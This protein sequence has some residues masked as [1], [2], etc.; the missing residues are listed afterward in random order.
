MRASAKAGLGG[1]TAAARHAWLVI[2]ASSLALLFAA[3]PAHA[4]QTHLFEETFGSAEVPTLDGVVAGGVAVD[5]ATG[6]LLVIEAGKSVIRRFKPNGEPDP[7]TALGSNTIDGKKGVGGKEC[8][9][10]AAS[11]DQTP[12]NG[13]MFNQAVVPAQQLAVDNSGTLTDG[14]IYLTQGIPGSAHVV[15]VFAESGKYLGQVA[16]AGPTPFAEDEWTPCGVAVDESGNLYVSGGKKV[17]KFDPSASPPLSSDLTATYTDSDVICNLA[18]GAG[19][20]AGALFANRTWSL[21]KNNVIKL[22]TSNLASKGVVTPGVTSSVSVDPVTGHLFTLDFDAEAVG[23]RKLREYDVAGSSADLLSTTSPFSTINVAVTPFGERLYSGS[24]SGGLRVY[25]PTVTVPEPSTGPATEI[26]ESGVTLTGSVNPDGVPLEECRFAYGPSPG[27]LNE[28]TPC[29]ESNAEIGTSTKAVHARLEG[30]P[31]ETTY[32]YM[33]VAKN[34]NGSVDGSVQT[35]RTPGKPVIEGQWAVSVTADSAVIKAKVNP[36]NSPTTYRLEWGETP[37]YGQSASGAVGSDATGH[38]VSASLTGLAAGTAYHYRVV[39]SNNL[40]EVEGEDHYLTTYRLPSANTNC[41]NQ[42]F[43]TGAAAALPN[44][45]AYEMVSPV[46]KENGD[47]ISPPNITGFPVRRYQASTDGE[48]LSYTSIRAFADAESA[49]YTT[50]YIASRGEGGWLTHAITP[51]QGYNRIN[52][53]GVDNQYLASTPDL[54]SSWFLQDTDPPLTPDAPEGFANVYRRENATGGF[55]A[56][57]NVTPPHPSRPFQPQLRGVSEDGSHSVFNA[58]D[59]LTPNARTA[60]ISQVYETS[61]GG[62]LRLVSVM[63]DGTASKAD[64]SA[65]DR[66]DSQWGIRGINGYHAVSAD[67]MRVYWTTGAGVFL[68]EN[69]PREQSAIAAGKCTEPEK[70]CTYPVSGAEGSEFAFGAADGSRALFTKEGGGK[71]GLYRYDHADRSMHLIAPNVK[72]VAGASD[73]A[74]RVYFYSEEVLTGAEENSAG[75]AARAGQ[76][77]LYLYQEGEGLAYV[78]TVNKQDDFLWPDT[79]F[80]RESRVTP[81]GLH[82]AFTSTASLT[83]Y[84]NT[85]AHSGKADAEVFIYDAPAGGSPGLLRC[86]SCNPSG[87]RPVGRSLRNFN[88]ED[89]E[90]TAAK[91][92]G[93]DTGFY[94]SRYFSEDGQRLFFE[95]YDSL[96]LRDTNGRR[97]VYEW[98]ALGSGDCSEG[99]PSFSELNG[100]CVFLISSGESPEDSQFVDASP[101]GRDVFFTTSASLVSWQDTGLVD[102]YDARAGGGFAPPPSPAPACEGEACQGTPEAP[103]DPT[104]ASLSFEGAGNVVEAASSVK[105]KPSCAKG[106]VRRKGRCVVKKQRHRAKR[107]HRRAANDKGRAAR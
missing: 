51:P 30:L 78:A 11:C 55:E 72:R 48:K 102:V 32:R 69:A 84:D 74:L 65:G 70:A 60:N 43:R 7:F 17:Y 71:V 62:P 27:P 23:P 93:W 12:Q 14:N 75:D 33:L 83:G 31:P 57:N 26:D 6:D 9:E 79:S 58:F 95:A 54:G 20:T 73:D 98:E 4:L 89:K 56:L 16:A 18:A 15:L 87:A 81:D 50:Q 53:A 66:F 42:A 3:A 35:F 103:N 52:V 24:L 25:G 77:N 44:C 22:A 94:P 85:D 86:A 34:E 38:T 82:V 90:W 5:P 99:N 37:A 96:S 101:D 19:P 97:D 100:G 8:A 107:A 41:P 67:G 64:S 36:E 46:D 47:I 1:I 104:P 91:I 105:P 76:P 80:F 2:A 88:E 106:K 40:G 13:F 92:T 21:A 59:N 45:R 68:R 10:E 61:P 29:A 63:P 39:V 49:R 28:T